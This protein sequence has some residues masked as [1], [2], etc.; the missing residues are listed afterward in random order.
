MLTL[1]HLKLVRRDVREVKKLRTLLLSMAPGTVWN[2]IV[3]HEANGSCCKKEPWRI[4][5]SRLIAAIK[6]TA[7]TIQVDVGGTP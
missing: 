3:L 5:A 2:A 7:T 1:D 4:T 6:P